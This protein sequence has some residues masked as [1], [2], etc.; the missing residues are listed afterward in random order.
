M[1][2]KTLFDSSRLGGKGARAQGGFLPRAAAPALLCAFLALSACAPI[3]VPTSNTPTPP[4]P[5]APA[6]THTP[7]PTYDGGAITI[8][9]L[10]TD[11]H[12]FVQNALYDSLLAPDPRTGAL[13]PA[14]AEA[15]QVSD[16]ALT[17]T[18]RLRADVKW[19]NGESL[20]AEDIAATINAFSAPT[21]RGTPAADFGTLT[22]ATA[23]DA[24]TVQLSFRE[25]YCP[26]LTSIGAM[27][28]FPRGVVASANFSRLTDAQWVGTGALKFVARDANQMV[29]TR[30]A[31][32][33]RGA[34]RIDEW[35]LKLY[36]DARALRAAFGARQVDVL[37]VNPRDLSAL[38]TAGAKIYDADAPEIILLLF[39][40]DSPIL[41]DVR[42]RQAL[43]RALDR[44]V[45]LND[46][47]GQGKSVDALALPDYWALP[48][49]VP[50][51]AYDLAG[52]RQLLS[53]ANWRD[54]GDG[55]LRRANRPLALELRTEGDDPLLEPLAF[56]IREQIAAL[57]ARVEL[58]LSD[59]GS[60]M[61]HAFQHRFDLLLLSRRIPLDP[62]Q[63]WY[64]QS[65]EN[66]KG[67]GFNFGSY[68]SARV[69]ALLKQLNRVGA[70][71]APARA[72]LFGEIQK[73]LQSDAPAVFLSVPKQ[74]IAANERVLGIA[75]SAFAGE[76]WNLR[77]WRVKP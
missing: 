27:K 70:C 44:A 34:P 73:Q 57:G 77:E 15:F 58:Q 19:H 5:A 66:K 4:P 3:P 75:P 7:T 36:P 40:T 67:D 63:R 32:Y 74:Y 47:G 48:K 39:N 30:N 61:A 50:S 64:W 51:S 26:A 16:D 33:W 9:A 18:F 6:V 71:D 38:K 2:L 60:W 24:Q 65:D 69:D 17:I 59:R 68:S 8:G 11:A 55:V 31:D 25:P 72:A 37:A 45:L 62:D 53:E 41:N 56:R 54:S 46:M 49:N 43:T 21:F 28:I 13:Q 42:T 1:I 20:T 35:T 10:D 22:R 12:A 23:L 14:L 76:W 29:L 52:A